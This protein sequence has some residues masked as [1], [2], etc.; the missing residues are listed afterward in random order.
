MGDIDL[1]QAFK[2]A[3]RIAKLVPKEL[4]KAAF[5][6]ALDELLGRG[7]E[8]KGGRERKPRR[9]RA[10]KVAPTSGASDK[11][12]QD[13]MEKVDRT[14]CPEI[15]SSREILDRSLMVL[16]LAKEKINIDGLSAT[17][18]SRILTDKFRVK[19]IR[20]SVAK[21]LDGARDKVDRVVTPPRKIRY[22]I[23]AA[24]EAYLSKGAAEAPSGHEAE[25]GRPSKKSKK[26]TAKKPKKKKTGKKRSQEDQEGRRKR[27]AANQPSA[28][29]S[30]TDL[31]E[32]GVLDSPKTISEV[33]DHLDKKKGRRYS[34]QNLS[35]GL[36]R[37]LRDEKV[38]REKNEDGQYEY[39][40]RADST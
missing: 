5:D 18:I 11:E 35:V 32:E 28:L 20:R 40:S 9:P 34:V 6:R 4:R 19:T 27:A 24:G 17:Q 15:T 36:L 29:Q 1:D 12:V 16:R 26:K 21:A 30:L 33:Q 23:M 13:F 7:G 25:V 8:R 3:A 10:S 14:G 2:E 31:V 38:E 39:K 37:L 22:R